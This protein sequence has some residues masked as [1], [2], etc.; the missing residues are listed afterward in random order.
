MSYETDRMDALTYALKN[1]DGLKYAVRDL[2]DNFKKI[3]ELT[4]QLKAFNENIHILDRLAT[5]LSKTNELLDQTAKP[6]VR[7]LC[8]ET[9]MF[10]VTVR[11]NT[12]S[13]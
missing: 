12:K 5:E 8:N 7:T 9:T 10:N 3:E 1:S 11:D 13:E 4:E 2:N 6:K